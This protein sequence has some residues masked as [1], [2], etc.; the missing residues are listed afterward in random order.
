MTASSSRPR[1]KWGW[2]VLGGLL[3]HLCT[4][5]V[6]AVVAAIA[7]SRLAA[8]S[9]DAAAFADASRKAGLIVGP[10]IGTLLAFLFGRWAARRSPGRELAAGTM[11]GG[12]AALIVTPLLVAA[13]PSARVVY[14]ASMGLKLAAGAAGGL[15]ASRRASRESGVAA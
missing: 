5:A 7:T 14:V 9:S 10:T 1:L 12:L 8:P 6:V 13:A 15:I 11:A 3:A 4:I 2:A